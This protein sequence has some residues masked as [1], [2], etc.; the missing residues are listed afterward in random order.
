LNSDFDARGKFFTMS[1]ARELSSLQITLRPFR[2]SDLEDFYGWAS[3]DEVTRFMTWETFKSKE[4]AR[5]FLKRVIIPHPWFRAICTTED[6]PKV[7]GHVVMEQGSGIHI[8]RAE[9]G[10]AISRKYW[11]NGFATKA[12]T[13]ALHTAFQEVEGLKRIQALVLPENVASQRVLHKAG[14]VPEGLLRSYVNIKGNIR[15]CILYG[16]V[17]PAAASAS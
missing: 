5:E 16:Y 1:S 15:D 9:V 4:K 12:L 17:S 8:C 6:K 11:G 2:E 3:D 13:R 7:I 14:F 10:Y